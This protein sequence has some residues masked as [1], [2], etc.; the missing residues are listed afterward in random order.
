MVVG[1]PP[2]SSWVSTLHIYFPCVLY[3][4]YSCYDIPGVG[5]S[6]LT[7][8]FIQ[9]IDSLSPLSKTSLYPTRGLAPKL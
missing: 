5:L 4:T 8:A 7:K 2:N 6:L 9:S 1:Y 3:E